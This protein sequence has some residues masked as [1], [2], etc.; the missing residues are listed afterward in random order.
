M[1][2]ARRPAHP[3]GLGIPHRRKAALYC[4]LAALLGTG[5]LWLIFHYFLQVRGE[6]GPQPHALEVWWLRLHGASAFVALWF[7]GLL[8]GTHAQPGL[9]Q[10]RWRVSGIAILALLALLALSGYL[11]YYASDDALRD[12]V[13]LL[14]WLTGL[15]LAI[16]LLIH[17][18][19]IRRS[20]K[21]RTRP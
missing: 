3:F 6:F 21:Q 11:L 15:G 10:T 4:A 14:H 16:P 19:G 8:W 18:L 2:G 5:I 17:V 7:A 9:R 13:R 20:K 1:N 12:L